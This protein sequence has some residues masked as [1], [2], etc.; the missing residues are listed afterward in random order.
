[1]KNH[2]IILHEHRTNIWQNPS[3]ITDSNFQQG[4]L[5]PKR[6]DLHQPDK[7]CLLKKKKKPSANIPSDETLNIF[8]LKSVISALDLRS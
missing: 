5:P 7:Y 1:M 6:K 4:I 8:P 3:S 2:V